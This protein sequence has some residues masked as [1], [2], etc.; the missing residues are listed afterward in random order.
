MRTKFA[1][2]RRRW[3]RAAVPAAILASWLAW[4]AAR[5]PAVGPLVAENPRTTAYIDRFRAERRGRGEPADVA[6]VWVRYDRISRQLKKAVLVAEDINFFSHSG[7]ETAELREAMRRAVTKRELPRGASTITQQLARNLW[8]SPSR[9]P[10]RKL[11]E[12]LLTRQI[13]RTLSKERILELYLNV[14]EFGPGIYGVEAA[15]RYYFGRSA[16]RLDRHQAA[17]LA[18]TLP[19]PSRL[20]PAT[21]AR[22]HWRVKMI[23]NRMEKAEFLDRRL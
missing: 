5:W 8:L 11:R 20:N 22:D 19:A 6:Q 17:R 21:I 1:W 12:A 2:R 4:E 18:A 16:R 3:R 10:L 9:N 15:A 14:A 23:L 7:F 13:E